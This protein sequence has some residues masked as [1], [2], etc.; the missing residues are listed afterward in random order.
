MGYFSRRVW[1]LS[2]T[3][4]LLLA[5][6]QSKPKTTAEAAA[7]SVLTETVSTDTAS[8]AA[9][10]DGITA[11]LLQHHTQV[12]ASDAFEGRRPFTAGEEKATRYLAAEFRKLGLQPGPNGTYFQSVPLVEITGMPA[13]VA[14]I[15]GHGNHLILQL[16]TDYVV[17]TGREVPSVTLTDS[18]MVFAGYGV[19]GPEYKWD[20]YAGLDCR[21]KTVVVLND[22]PGNA[23]TDTTLFKGKALTLY[24][25]GIRG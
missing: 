15:V 7:A 2:A 1:S 10:A 6:C 13:P 16:R 8:V 17:G 5:S 9:P 12:L 3:A 24:S 14:T 19:V 23:G 21:G 20:D 4:G 22:D 18:P 11:G 25:G